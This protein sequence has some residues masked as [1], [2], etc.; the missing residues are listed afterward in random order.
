MVDMTPQQV[1]ETKQ[2]MLQYQWYH[3]IDL[4]QGLITPG[5]YDHRPLIQHYGLPD[6]VA[7]KTVLDV[8]PAQGFFAFE[9]EKRGAARV[10]TVELPRWSEHDGSASLKASFQ[11]DQVD[12]HNEDYLHG[13]LK[14]A[15]ETRHS[16]VEQMYCNVYD[17]G[18]STTGLFDIVFCGSLL[19]HLTDPLRALYALRSVTRD[20]AIITTPLD[21]DRFARKP[22]ALFHGVVNGQA[23]WA[24]NM[25]C[26]EHWAL[27]A[28]FNRV[29]RVS[30]FRLASLDG[31]FNIPHGT[32]RAFV[33][34]V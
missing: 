23:F 5:Q 34:Q 9:F 4:G 29:E 13:A 21:P 15:I 1:L 27:A 3:T 28:G 25:L 16:K 18:P 11:R 10:V 17:L 14:F 33:E 6:R 8:G 31:Q 2:K 26:L 20:Y 7:G 22:R 32:I 19:I 12:I 30:T 24:P